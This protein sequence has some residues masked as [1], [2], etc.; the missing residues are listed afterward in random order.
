MRKAGVWMRVIDTSD[1][2]EVTFATMRTMLDPLANFDWVTLQ[3]KYDARC[4][5]DGIFQQ[6][7][8]AYLGSFQPTPNCDRELYYALVKWFAGCP[9]SRRFCETWKGRL[10]G[11]LSRTRLL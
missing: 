5:K 9:R 10:E 1:L 3:E 2:T 7:I 8:S 6:G 4:S 11:H